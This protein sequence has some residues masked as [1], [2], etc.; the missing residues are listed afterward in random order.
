MRMSKVRLRRFA[1][2][3]SAAALLLAA[4][5]ARAQSNS[6]FLVPYGSRP[7][8]PFFAASTDCSAK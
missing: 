5:S 1:A 7:A 4:G 2:S 6:A 8:E 3:T